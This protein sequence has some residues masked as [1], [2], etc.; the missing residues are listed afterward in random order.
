[1]AIGSHAESAAGSVATQLA[2]RRE[3]EVMINSS[4]PIGM[5]GVK[6]MQ[7]I[8]GLRVQINDTV[9]PCY[10]RVD[11]KRWHHRRGYA[12]RINKKW[13][14]RFGVVGTLPLIPYGTFYQA[15]P[16]LVMN[17]ETLIRM[18][19]LMSL[20]GSAKHQETLVPRL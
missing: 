8:L 11:P 14:R 6:G 7:S 19:A 20:D 4:N 9:V 12:E 17:S 13:K 18:K 15:G 10:R 1:M 2:P 5:E 16:V 3:G